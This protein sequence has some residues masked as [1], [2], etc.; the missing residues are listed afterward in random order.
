M[1]IYVHHHMAKIWKKQ[2]CST[3]MDVSESFSIHIMEHYA[4]IRMNSIV[5]FEVAW[6]EIEDIMP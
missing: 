3:K 2:N 6:M 1:H 4:I 5:Q